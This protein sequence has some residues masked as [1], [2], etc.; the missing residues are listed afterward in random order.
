MKLDVIDT[1]LS[2]FSRMSSRATLGV[3]G[4]GLALILALIAGFMAGSALMNVSSILGALVMVLTFGVYIA[5]AAS[6]SIGA[7]RAFDEED[8][9]LDMFTDNI[10]WPFLRMTGANIVTQAFILTVA[11]I[12]FYPLILIGFAGAGA[13]E[14]T[15]T[16]MTGISSGLMLGAGVVG[17]LALLIV[18]Y[19]MSA[20]TIS[21]PRIAVNNQ[22]MFQAL[23][24]SIQSTKGNRPGIIA[25][26]LPFAALLAAAFAG[27]FSG[28]FL[29]GAIYIVSI[30]V[31]SLYYLSLLTELNTRLE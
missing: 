12:L 6:I 19:I 26:M 21:L 28:G 27:M 16:G 4:A 24:E 7:L 31:G 30:L 10:V 8:V 11:Y 3:V 18:L 22:R 15:S 1:V 9:S 20:L 23:D 2:S 25:T 29:G 14:M 17:L 5:G 13:A